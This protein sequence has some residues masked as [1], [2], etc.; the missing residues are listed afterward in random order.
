MILLRGPKT[1][2]DSGKNQLAAASGEI[3]NHWTMC[4]KLYRTFVRR[5]K[6][7]AQGVGPNFG[8]WNLGRT[9]PLDA[10]RLCVRRR[11]RPRVLERPNKRRA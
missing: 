11:Q 4:L 9:G 8:T 3:E 7:G 5:G 6:H 10:R 2:G 1:S